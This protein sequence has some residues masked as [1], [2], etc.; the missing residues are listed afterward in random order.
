MTTYRIAAPDGKTYRIDGPEGAT[1]DQVQAEVVRQNPHLSAASPA[2]TSEPRF[3][4]E[5]SHQADNLVGGAIQWGGN[6]LTYPAAAVKAAWEGTGQSGA[7][8]N[9]DS[10]QK[11][12]KDYLVGK[13]VDPDSV[14]YTIG[15]E[16]PPILATLPVG[17]FAGGSIK[18]AGDALA[19]SS[20]KVAA[21]LTD[22][23]AATR[24]GGF[25][26]N[27]GLGTNVAGGAVTGALSSAA[28][29]PE[30][31][32][33]GMGAA[34]GGALPVAGK[35][36]GQVA[37]PFLARM[38][39]TAA[40]N[41]LAEQAA[42]RSAR[43]GLGTA[44][45]NKAA[46]LA[47]MDNAQT[48]IPGAVPTAGEAVAQSGLPASAT[49]ALQRDLAVSGGGASDAFT[50]ASQRNNNA[51]VDS[52]APY[53]GGVDPEAA[54]KAARDYRGA[55]AGAEYKALDSVTK[56]IDAP[57]A[58]ILSNDTVSKIIPLAKELHS[59]AELNAKAKGLPPVAPFI[60]GG[61]KATPA[62]P[63]SY[64]QFNQS[65]VAGKPAIPGTPDE[66]SIG[67]LQ[68]IKAALDKVSADPASGA[69]LGIS[70]N[71]KNAMGDL[72][73]LLTGWM[74]KASPEWGKARAGYEAQSIPINQLQANQALAAKLRNSSE[75]ITP[76]QFLNATDT[77][78]AA[79]LKKSGVPRYAGGID[80]FLTRP[81]LDAISGIKS[82]LQRGIDTQTAESLAGHSSDAA[83]VGK[84]T[85][86]PHVGMGAILS[87][88]LGK[89]V[90]GG[91]EAAQKAL[92][93]RMVDAGEYAKLLRGLPEDKQLEVVR[94]LLTQGLTA[95]SGP[96]LAAQ[97]RK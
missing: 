55:N 30:L 68:Y 44:A 81:N 49:S 95:G 14:G 4:D 2:P 46:V 62:V 25:A 75:K 15:K 86:I 37:K 94:R 89:S 38:G 33:A 90:V 88:V 54:L 51:M 7:K 66:V 52:L 93:T 83:S 34:L 73:S 12:V 72:K 64:N 53:A 67:A 70:A 61:Q 6:T 84:A 48:Y 47:A 18:A 60:L 23:A 45:E 10:M 11:S 78:E 3:L 22:L 92:A 71:T 28:I 76:A 26:K 65:M 80:D 17:G 96:A 1:Q 50:R 24:A 74:E 21:Y 31:S 69:A 13:G 8:A 9:V 27:V 16:A 36:V 85:P 20:P 59:I 32:S 87:D 97:L 56:P 82:Q 63:Q 40:A 41:S 39:S 5:L 35:V 91:G 79:M 57:L 42:N 77:G 43:E 29:D 58:D 19:P